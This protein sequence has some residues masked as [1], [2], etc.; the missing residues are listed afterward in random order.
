M[1]ARTLAVEDNPELLGCLP[2]GAQTFA[3]VREGEGLVGWGEVARVELTGPDHFSA[4]ARWWELT[5]AALDIDDAVGVPGTG[6]IAFASFAFD[7]R[8]ATSVVVVPR[9]LVG[10]R[11]GRSWITVLDAADHPAPPISAPAAIPQ[12]PSDVHYSEGSRSAVQ[13]QA[14]VAEA[15]RRI[16]NGDLDKVVLA[17]DLVAT[18]S[19]AVD[20]RYLLRELAGHYPSCWTFAVDGLVGATPELLIRR[21]GSQVVSRVLAGTVN[22]LGDDV[23]DGALAD[24]L[25]DSDKDLA[26]HRIAVRS[27]A[28]A[29][30]DHCDELDVQASPRILRLPNVQH[31]A[32]DVSGRLGDNATVLDLAR[33]LHPTAAVCGTPT[34]VALDLIRELEGMDRGRYAG[35]VGWLGADGDGELGIALRCA[36]VAGRRVRLFAGCGIVA[37]SDP[38]SELAEAQAKFVPIRDALGV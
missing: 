34:D 15:V 1:T 2:D 21:T 7:G 18:A 24:A 19:A 12:A 31:L 23:A 28:A 22:R 5:R 13:W 30:A 17:R 6:P 38:M 33:S 10:R 29:L 16:S 3:W 36:E 26:E 37:G 27:V 25:L 32:T 35:P 9:V 14:A 20:Q 8:A 11:A 4:A